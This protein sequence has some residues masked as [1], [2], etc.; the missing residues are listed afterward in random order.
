VEEKSNQITAI[1]A[2]LH[3]LACKNAVVS[4]DA[5]ACQKTIVAQIREQQADSVISL[6][7]N[8]GNYMSKS[9]LNLT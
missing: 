8:Q 9:G 3:Q 6:K 4:I 5:I 7:G 2:L 1:P